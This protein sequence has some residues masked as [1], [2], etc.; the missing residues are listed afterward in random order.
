[1][2]Y[3]VK[4]PAGMPCVIKRMNK[5]NI[6]E[7]PHNSYVQVE[8][9]SVNNG[10]Q[11]SHGRY[12]IRKAS[13]ADNDTGIY[14]EFYEIITT[15]TENMVKHTHKK[16]MEISFLFYKDDS[17]ER[18]AINWHRDC[19]MDSGRNPELLAF[20]VLDVTMPVMQTGRLIAKMGLG[21][22]DKKYVAFYN[23]DRPGLRW[24]PDYN[25]MVCMI[26]GDN[27]KVRPLLDYDRRVHHDDNYVKPLIEL[28]SC[29]GAGYIVDQSSAIDGRIIVH[30]REQRLYHTVRLTMVARCTCSNDENEMIE[31][32]IYKQ[33]K[34]IGDKNTYIAV[35]CSYE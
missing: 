28:K 32:S 27:V 19:W 16:Y 5:E 4:N 3:G 22:I 31:N 10:L 1:M 7:L 8:R 30:S 11:G 15:I 18:H 12:D 35:P 9:I 25:P 17:M 24:S 21:S 2:T 14:P 34:D 26:L 29:T 20:A 6:K 13:E 33:I 23:A